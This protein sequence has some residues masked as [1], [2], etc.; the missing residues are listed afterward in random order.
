M[1]NPTDL[2]IPKGSAVLTWGA[3]EQLG[4]NF[5]PFLNFLLSKDVFVINV[6]PIIE[7]FNPKNPMDNHSIEYMKKRNYLNGYLTALK[8][9]KAKIL[10]TQRLHFG[11]M[12]YE[13]WS[14]VIWRSK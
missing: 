14:F 8:K 7:L 3:L 11:N 2:D 1:F 5:Q 12:N 4:T 13:G 9:S 10:R 6:E